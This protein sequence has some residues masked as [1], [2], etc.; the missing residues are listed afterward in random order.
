[1]PKAQ[2]RVC[3]KSVFWGFFQPPQLP[4]GVS[5]WHGVLKKIKFMRPSLLPKPAVMF[6]F[7]L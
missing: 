3:V 6:I 1:M 7:K 5:T 4:F 2:N